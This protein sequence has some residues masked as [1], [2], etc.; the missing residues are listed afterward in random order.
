MEKNVKKNNGVLVTII[1]LLCLICVGMGIYIFMNREKLIVVSKNDNKEVNTSNEKASDTNNNSTKIN[2]PASSEWQDEKNTWN[3]I[4]GDATGMGLSYKVDYNNRHVV[5]AIVN[6]DA[7]EGRYNSAEDWSNR[8]GKENFTITFDQDVVDMIVGSNGQVAS[9]STVYFLL[10]DGSVYKVNERCA[11]KGK[12]FQ[13]VKKDENAKNIVK[14]YHIEAV[15]KEM[16]GAIASK[17]MVGMTKDGHL[18]LLD[19]DD[20]KC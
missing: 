2:F 11:L 7:I 12:N 9:L 8:H 1:V 17:K 6:W 14:F 4:A 19:F 5:N 10:N 20:T 15:D 3:I 13:T 16:D 18:Q